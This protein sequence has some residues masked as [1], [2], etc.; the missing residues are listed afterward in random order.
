MKIALYCVKLNCTISIFNPD[1]DTDTAE[2]NF[3]DRSLRFFD[4][5]CKALTTEK[6]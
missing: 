6:H 5:L 1:T 3:H 2:I 4:M